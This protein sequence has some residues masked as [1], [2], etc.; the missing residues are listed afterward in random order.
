MRSSSNFRSEI[1]TLLKYVL[2]YEVNVWRLLGIAVG[3]SASCLL[4]WMPCCLCFFCSF[5]DSL[6][7]RYYL[8]LLGPR[9]AALFCQLP[10]ACWVFYTVREPAVCTCLQMIRP[11]LDWQLEFQTG[12]VFLVCM[13]VCWVYS[14]DV[15]THWD[16]NVI[17]D[18]DVAHTFGSDVKYVDLHV[19]Q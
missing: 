16:S 14:R 9:N 3:S 7:P 11:L 10:S 5:L 12:N 6:S 1:H 4:T 19:D 17:Q 13:C 2:K 18:A 8:V 15:M